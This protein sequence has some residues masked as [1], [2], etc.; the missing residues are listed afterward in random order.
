MRFIWIFLV[1]L[2]LIGCTEEPAPVPE[3]ETTEEEVEIVPVAE[4]ETTESSSEDLDSFLGSD[5]QFQA[6]Y[7]L[8]SNVP[9]ALSSATVIYYFLDNSH[10]RKDILTEDGESRYLVAGSEQKACHHIS[11]DWACQS[12]EFTPPAFK[13][14]LFSLD[15]SEYSVVSNP[16]KKFGSD[17]ASCFL[18]TNKSV[19]A[20]FCFLQ[21]GI[22][23]YSK[24]K[25]G[26]YIT[27]YQALSI[28]EIVD[29]Q[30]F[31]LP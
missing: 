10:Q 19:T 5:Q 2:V 29:P 11:G 25:E 9:N 24:I 8:E 18:L 7:L 13:E 17:I 15:L 26:E 12:K 22:L 14:F 4:S 23:T 31:A 28:E 6:K 21:S 3:Q 16:P 1:A 30:I 27:F 20:E